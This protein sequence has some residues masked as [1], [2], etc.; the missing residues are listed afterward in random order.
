MRRRPTLDACNS[1]HAQ[2]LEW[3]PCPTS[4]PRSLHRGR[5]GPRPRR[6]RTMG[7]PD[8]RARILHRH[9]FPIAP[10]TI[11]ADSPDCRVVNKYVPDSDNAVRSACRVGDPLCTTDVSASGFSTKM[12][13]PASRARNARSKCVETGVA[14]T[15]A[16]T[17]GSDKTTP[18]SSVR[19]RCGKRSPMNCRRPGFLSQTHRIWQSSRAS[20]LRIRLGPQ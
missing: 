7:D 8:S 19:R 20:K 13:L 15:T 10:A 2:S 16:S 9:N 4:L 1:S 17:C 12:C 6:L 5:R 11:S 3:V 14:I 18:R